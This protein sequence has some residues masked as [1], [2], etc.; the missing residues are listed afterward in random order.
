MLLLDRPLILFAITFLLLWFSARLGRALRAGRPDLPENIRSDYGTIV[1][2]TLTL[3]GLLIGFTFS[4]ATSRYD[5]RKNLEEEEA[6]AIGTEYLRLSFLPDADAA[7]LRQMLTLYTDLRIRN[8]TSRDPVELARINTDTA[9][10]QKQMWA[11][12][13]AAAKLQP[14]PLAALASSG[15]NDVLNA[16]GYVQAAWWNRIP[17][18]AWTLMFVIALLCNLLLGYGA[19]GREPVL[20]IIVPLAVALSFFL[21]AD[22]D[23]P[24]G[25]LI[26]VQPQNLHALKQGL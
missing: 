20:S 19:R 7:S 10:L 17:F 11:Q 5:A 21:V 9:N 22:I 4:M 8:Y 25:G 6:N 3:L 1:G 23:S 14:T 26:R 24:R 2:A 15:M 16:Q 12:T 13:A 18:A